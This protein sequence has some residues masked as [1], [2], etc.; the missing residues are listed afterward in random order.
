MLEEK[1]KH[2]YIKII[3]PLL[4]YF[5]LPRFFKSFSYI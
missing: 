1:K 5:L 2:F 3:L 4:P